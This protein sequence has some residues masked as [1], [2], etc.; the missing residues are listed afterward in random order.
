MVV[1]LGRT[2]L[3][4]T[5]SAGMTSV[6]ARTPIVDDNVSESAEDFMLTATVT[7]GLTAN[8]I[9]NSTVT[10]EDDDA[11]SL[12]IADVTVVEGVDVFAEFTISLS[13]V[14]F[15]DISVDLALADGSAA[16]LGVDYGASGVGNLEVSTDG[17]VTWTDASSA[18]IVA[19]MTNVLARTPIVD[20]NVS[21]SA[22]DFVFTATV[23]SGLT[24]NPVANSSVTI[25]DNDAPSLSIADVTVVEGVDVF[26]EFTIS[27]SAVSIEDISV[28]L[29]LVDG[30][31]AGLGVD[32]GSAGVGNLEVSTDSGATWTDATSATFT[33][34]TTSVLA[35]TPIVDDSAS[36][37]AEDFMLTATVTS[38]ATTNAN[39]VS[40]VTIED[41]DAPS[42]S[43]A[44]LF[45]VEGSDAFAEF[46]IS[47]STVSFEDISVDLA[48]ADGSAAGVGVDYGSAGAGNLEVSTDDGVT[49]TDTTSAIISA[50]M[51][52]VLART[53]IVDDNVSESAEDFMLTATVTS[54][55]TA[56]PSSSSTVTMEDNDAPSLSIADL[57]VVE[58][59]DAFAE[60]TISLSIVSFEDISVDLA[61]A[62]GSAAGLGVDYGTSGVGNLEVS[63]DGGVT[64][65]DATIA[66][67]S[68]GMMSVLARTPIVDDNVSESAEDFMLTATVASG[69][70]A[71][72]IANSTVTIEDDD[73]PS[74]SIADVTVVEGVDVFAEFTISLSTV[75]FEDISFDLALA[76]G[77]AAGLGVDYGTSG[78]GNLEVSTDGGVTWA[79]ATIATISAGMTSVLAR[80]P[81]VD[82]NVSESA[83]DFTLTATVTSGLTANPSSNSTITIEDN[84][85]PSLSMADLSV[86]EGVDA[87]AE[88]TII[89]SNVSFEDISFDLA[90]ADGLAL[91]LGVDYGSVGT[92]DLEVSTDSGVTWADATSATIAAGMTSVL[93]RTPIVDDTVSESAEDF[94]LTAAVSSGATTNANVLSTVTI[95]DND[96]PSLSVADLT[97]TEGV[98]TFA[99]FTISLS[100]VSFEAI[101]VDLALADG[102]AA[103][104]GVGLWQRG[105]WQSGGVYRRWRH[106][107]RC[108]QRDDYSWRDECAGP[109]ADCG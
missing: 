22:E 52:S 63:T 45:V 44:D 40:S 55:L 70:T 20:D 49:W 74:L 35:R 80:T 5:I 76:D 14:S 4:A 72:A 98:D 26:A 33:A 71:N 7:S 30:S 6:L 77:A 82:D 8:A 85:A 88:F 25:E 11:P 13:T 108:V 65:A 39:A 27:L 24:A 87:F 34:G 62:D 69:L 9:A 19:G 75:S 100:T 51:T 18:T 101:S 94:T 50:G 91:G 15:E 38:G 79:D 57:N 41:N 16:G 105:S 109:Y 56:N 47:L 95:E 17:G 61:L 106:L 29:A 60:I 48:L 1:L 103:G 90:L 81:I 31:A 10:I 36:E 59:S 66:T 32:Y 99:E 78:V 73:A 2:R 84:D 12:L 104:L 23:T 92:G 83:E 68:A 96:A 89:L 54:G 67:I 46:T 53:P 21:E 58:G 86:T 93:V 3:A 37:P 42:L 43:I 28:D 107:G 102:A 64:W 97:V